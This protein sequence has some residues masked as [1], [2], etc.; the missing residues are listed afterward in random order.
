MA[1]PAA[2][3]AVGKAMSMLGQAAAGVGAGVARR[4]TFQLAGKNLR[5]LPRNDPDSELPQLA[6]TLRDAHTYVWFY[7]GMTDPLRRQNERFAA[8]LAAAGIPHHYFEAAGGHNWALWRIEATAACQCGAQFGWA[9][10][11]RW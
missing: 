11:K 3:T 10:H 1:I 7:S 8:A 2:P 6:Q 4:R 5:L 9:W